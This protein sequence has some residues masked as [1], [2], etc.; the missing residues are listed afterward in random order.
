MPLQGAPPRR[1]PGRLFRRSGLRRVADADQ[2]EDARLQRLAGPGDDLGREVEIYWR[3][4]TPSR[5]QNT[6]LA[7]DG[8]SV[9]DVDPKGSGTAS[10]ANLLE[11]Y[12][13]PSTRTHHTASGVDSLHFIY[14]ADPDRPLKSA[15][16]N[17]GVVPGHR[18]QDRARVADR[19]SRIGDRWEG[20]RG[21]QRA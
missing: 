5:W 9:V 3:S 2:Q 20:L 18:H 8:W 11:K 14:R 15:P 1:R 19:G 6:A 4:F 16:L 12:E 7:L 17:P 21:G 10:L 13:L